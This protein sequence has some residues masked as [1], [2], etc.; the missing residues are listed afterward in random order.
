MSKSYELDEACKNAIRRRVSGNPPL[1]PHTQTHTLRR[2]RSETERFPEA[3]TGWAIP[4]RLLTI[5]TTPTKV[6]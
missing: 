1:H 5:G 6:R 2:G 4:G 3:R